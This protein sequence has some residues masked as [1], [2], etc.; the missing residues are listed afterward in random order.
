MGSTA[1]LVADGRT[2]YH[3]EV[4]NPRDLAAKVLQLANAPERQIEMRRAA[5]REFEDKYTANE[6]YEQLM[7]IYRRAGACLPVEGKSQDH[8]SDLNRIT[9][10]AGAA[11]RLHGELGPDL[12]AVGV[13]QS[14]GETS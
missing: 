10:A 11:G 14:L 1:E 8:A 2:G 6:N 3:F 4:G 7:E 9:E 12:A 5:R 13:N